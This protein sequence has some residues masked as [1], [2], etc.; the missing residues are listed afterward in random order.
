MSEEIDDLTLTVQA[1]HINGKRVRR[2][3]IEQVPRAGCVH[4]PP[5]ARIIGWV[6]LSE[7]VECA[8]WSKCLQDW[9]LYRDR[10]DRLR[11]IAVY[12]GECRVDDG[13]ESGSR[14]SYEELLTQIYLT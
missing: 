6:R 13:T 9:L 3:F 10:N 7:K 5:L 14:V 12:G 2:S 11:R 4:Y 1:I 8:G